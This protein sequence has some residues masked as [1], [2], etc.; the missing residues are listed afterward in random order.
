MSAARTLTTRR[1]TIRFP[2]F[3]PVTTFGRKY[4]LDDLV[5]PYLPRLAP[6]ALVSLFYARQMTDRPRLPLFVDSGGFALLFEGSRVVSERGLGVLEITREEGKERLTPRAVLEFQ[7]EHAEVAFTLDFPSPPGTEA[8]EAEL[9]HR[10]TLANAEW[11]LANRR[12]RDL[13]LYAC[14]QA[15]E[16]AAVR[17]SCRALARGA[18]DGFAIGGLIPRLREPDVVFDTIR[19]VREEIGDRPLHAFGLGKPEFIARAFAAGADSVDSSSYVKLAANGRLWG[20]PE[21]RLADPS[22]TDRLHLALC[23][24]ATATRAPL[25]L[26]VGSLLFSTRVLESTISERPA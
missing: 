11:A 2:A 21:V 13:P 16:A 18:F 22:P 17:S 1:G 4:P 6:A 7:E 9:R 26:G 10:L 24:L 14:I 23:N 3:I 25:P 15:G 20:R 5:R 19:L 8:R 12:R